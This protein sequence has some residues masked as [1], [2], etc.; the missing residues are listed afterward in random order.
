MRVRLVRIIPKNQGR[1]RSLRSR[2]HPVVDL[3]G[4]GHAGGQDDGRRYVIDMNADGDTLGEAHP[5][6][7]RIDGGDALTVR[8][9]IRDVDRAGDTVDV[10]ANDRA[11]AHQLDPGRIADAD[12]REVRLLEIPV[13]PE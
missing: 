10:T 9:R 4:G 13:D 7:N 12:G 6:E 5:R 11:V 3:G 2:A 1:A 8:L